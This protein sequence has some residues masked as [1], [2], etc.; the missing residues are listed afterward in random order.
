MRYNHKLSSLILTI[1]AVASSFSLQSCKD[2]PDEFKLSDG[3]PTIYYI[4][5]ASYSASD[6]LLVEAAPQTS[7]CLVGSNLKSIQQLYFNDKKAVLNTS[8]ITDNTLFVQ[9]PS[10]IPDEVS[11]KIYMITQ[12]HDTLTYDFHVV[13]P[14]PVVTAMK[15]EWVKVGEDAVITGQYFIDDPNQPLTV[16]FT[17]ISNS[18]SVKVPAENF[19]SITRS[20][21]VFT[22]PEG[23]EEGQIEVA[24]VYGKGMSK[25]YFRDSRNLITNFDGATDVIPQGWNIAATYSDVNGV[26]G[27]YVQLGPKE[28]EGG[29]VE[30]LKLPFWCGNWNGDPMS[31][32]S[33][34][35]IPLRN[36]LDFSDWQNMSFKMELYIPKSNPWSAGAMQILFVNHK[37][38]ANDSWQN[39]TYIHTKADGGLDLPRAL[40]R[41][42]ETTGSFDTGDEWIT[43]TIPLT[44]FVYNFDGT[45]VNSTMS[46]DSFDSFVIWPTEGGVAGTTCTPI[47]RYDNIRVVP[48]L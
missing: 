38:C 44:D 30:E 24:S 6:S 15:N 40:Y 45:K 29:W 9:I 1:I 7:I 25:F 48:N 46:I 22:V 13:I 33:G 21:L 28:T 26:D 3:T 47:F 2:Q 5:P 37:Q 27:K 10:D 32:T 8:Y 39:N 23:A 35:G 12:A 20:Q 14:A 4:R 34:A 17:G 43:V 16:T 42:W 18:I 19:K 11:D 41:P 31:I 36:F